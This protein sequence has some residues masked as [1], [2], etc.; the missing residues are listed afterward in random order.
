GRAAHE[1]TPDP[2]AVTALANLGYRV[3]AKPGGPMGWGP[4]GPGVRVFTL[5]G[6]F[7]RIM[8]QE[9]LPPV[10]VLGVL[11]GCLY[12][13][14]WSRSVPRWLLLALIAADLGAAAWLRPTDFA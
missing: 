1:P 8:L 7:K 10:A 6:E 11:L 3:Q 14:P 5:A 4:R 2:R 12:F 13:F 9:L